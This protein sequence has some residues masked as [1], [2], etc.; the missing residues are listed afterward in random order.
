MTAALPLSSFLAKDLLASSASGGTRPNVV[1]ILTDQQQWKA[2]GAYG[3]RVVRTPHLDRLAEQGTRF[4]HAYCNMASCMASRASLFTGQ[5]PHT[6]RAEFGNPGLGPEHVAFSDILGKAS[7]RTGYVGKWHMSDV[8]I[9]GFVPP[10]QRHGFQWWVAANRGHFKTFKGFVQ[11]D[12]TLFT[13]S[14]YTTDFLTDQAIAFVRENR[15]S[16][17]LLTL[18]IPDPHSPY[19]VRS[20]YDTMYPP[21]QMQ[22]PPSYVGD[23]KELPPYER[24]MFRVCQRQIQGFYQDREYR[25][26]FKPTT[27]EQTL[28]VIISQYYGMI[29]CIDENVGRL[30]GVFDELGLRENTIVIYTSDHGDYMGAHGLL[31]KGRTPWDEAMRI[32]LLISCP[33]RARGGVVSDELVSLID[34]MP[35]ILELTNREAP[36]ALDGKSLVPLLLGEETVSRDAVYYEFWHD[37]AVRRAYRCI[38]TKTWKYVYVLLPGGGS[39]EELLYNMVE[40]P[41]EMRDLASDPQHAD[42]KTDLYNRLKAWNNANNT[43]VIMP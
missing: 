7:Y 13:G 26:Q 24:G 25:E 39:P 43:G 14:K 30:M 5:Y 37:P 12:P 10:E 40:D 8:G 28:T 29:S 36:G 42:T 4:T 41:Y 17:F 23:P 1:L 18:S 22:L 38:R 27:R 19:T 34:I 3:N 15:G 6:H 11:D 20:P 16:P 35:T 32:P 21:E 33:G 31:Y 9:P 2:L